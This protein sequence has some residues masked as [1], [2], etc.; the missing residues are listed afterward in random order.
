MRR[1]DIVEHQKDI[2]MEES[3][4]IMT[5]SVTD[6]QWIE[7][8]FVEEIVTVSQRCKNLECKYWWNR[9]F[10]FHNGQPRV[11]TVCEKV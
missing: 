5:T 10:L 4:L 11:F 2:C 7:K 6:R 9:F 1:E 8:E 3:E